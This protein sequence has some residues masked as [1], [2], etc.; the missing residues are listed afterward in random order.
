MGQV[1][2]KELA[3]SLIKR[4]A[5]TKKRDK[6]FQRSRETNAVLEEETFEGDFDLQR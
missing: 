2:L 3:H 6:G 1:A 5:N 4:E